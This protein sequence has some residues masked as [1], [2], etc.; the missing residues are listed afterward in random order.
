MFCA[1]VA[2]LHL[3]NIEFD[4]DVR[5]YEFMQL[6]LFDS[7]NLRGKAAPSVRALKSTLS[8]VVNC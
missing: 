4:E 8:K 2:V 3:G 7:V 6:Y 5:D 1:V